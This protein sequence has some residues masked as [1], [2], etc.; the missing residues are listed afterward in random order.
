MKAKRWGGIHFFV[1]ARLLLLLHWFLF[2]VRKN[3]GN[4]AES[5]IDEC[6]CSKRIATRDSVGEFC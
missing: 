1:E 4:P 3:L 6:R 2:S 5:S